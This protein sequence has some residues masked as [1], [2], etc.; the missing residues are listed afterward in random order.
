MI[1]IFRSLPEVS[2]GILHHSQWPY[3][4]KGLKR[5]IEK[6]KLYN[7]YYCKP[8]KTNHFLIRLLHTVA[9]PVSMTTERYYINVDAVAMTVAKGLRMTS[10]IDRGSLFRGVFYG[11]NNPEII[12]AVDDYFDPEEV[13]ANW[14][15]V[16]AVTPLLH[17]KSDLGIHIP[18]GVDYSYETGLA[19]IMVN[20]PMLCVQYRAYLLEQ[21]AKEDEAPRSIAQFIAAYVLPNMLDQQTDL[22]IFN[23]TY[24]LQFTIDT[25]LNEPFRKHPFVMPKYD[26]LLD[27][28]ILHSLDYIYKGNLTFA[29]ILKTLP[30]VNHANLYEAL[31]MPD[32]APTQQIDW[33]LVMCRLKAVDFL[34]RVCGDSLLSKNQLYVNQILKSFRINNVYNALHQYLPSE[35]ISEVNGYVETIFTGSERD[36]FN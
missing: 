3:V 33:V 9:V 31:V 20:I 16:S 11:S 25:D 26:Q 35:I 18:N 32:I 10:S 5:N 22:A 34:F 36:Y 4:Q 2:L 19:V 29:K 13:T 14:K 23:R 27:Y 24:N 30:S 1:E 6:V 7:E 17:P 12:I 15:R 21:L 8:V 28:S